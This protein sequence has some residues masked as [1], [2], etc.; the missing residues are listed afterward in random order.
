MFFKPNFC[1]GCGEKIQRAEWG[2][3]TS[4]RFCDVCAIEN[5]G[6]EWLPRAV[7]LSA[8]LIGLFGFGSYLRNPGPVSPAALKQADHLRAAPVS[9]TALK[10]APRELSPGSRAVGTGAMAGTGQ[11]T[12]LGVDTPEPTKEQPRLE[13]IASDEPVHFCGAMTKKG[14]PCSRRVKTKGRCWQHVG[15]PSA[16][17]SRTATEVY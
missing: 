4:R 17:A 2:I 12:S 13:S 15:Q 9:E 6:H 5:Q 7:V 1:C 10:P 11:E 3:L 16:L 8:V 14:K